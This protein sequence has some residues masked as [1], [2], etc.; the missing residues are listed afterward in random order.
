M[1]TSAAVPVN[2]YLRKSYRPD[3]DYVDGEIRER[4]LGERDHADLQSRFVFLLCLAEHA[5]H[6]IARP[7]LRVQ[8]KPTRFRV[9]DVCVLR[10][11]APRE[12]IVTQPPLVCI[13]VLSPE[14]TMLR[15]RE[16]VRDYLEMGV[17]EVWVVDPATRSV[18]I[19][20]GTT[21]VE[22]TTGELK[23]PETPVVLSISE[24]FKVLDEY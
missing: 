4:N 12:Q 2:E 9:P 5:I 15:T 1:A 10:R 11:N 3:R 24:I 21:T 20:A 7:E 17:P 19:C 18:M 13:E 6:V 16:R 23:V 22:Q 8:V 14:D